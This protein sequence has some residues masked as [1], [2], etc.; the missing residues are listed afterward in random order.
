MKKVKVL[1]I[2]GKINVS[3]GAYHSLLASIKKLKENGIVPTVI[4]PNHGA[5]ED[6]FR[7]ENIEC[8]MVPYPSCTVPADAPSKIKGILKKIQ[9]FGAEKKI[10]KIIERNQYDI[11]HI[12]VGTASAGAKAAIKTGTPLVWH[13]REFLED[14]VNMT[15]IDQAEMKRLL[16]AADHIIAIS[17]A[18]KQA[19]QE[20]YGIEKATTAYNGILIQSYRKKQSFQDPNSV[21]F[22]LVGRIVREKGQLEA[23]KAFA[24]LIMT[25]RQL[26]I[27]L[28]IVGQVGDDKY[29]QEL[30]EYVRQHNLEEQ[31]EF[32]S[33][34]KDLSMLWENTDI[35]LVTSK[36]EGFGRVTAEFMFNNIPVIGAD[37][38]ATTELLSNNRGLLYCYGDADMLAEKMEYAIEHKNEMLKMAHIAHEYA[39]EN[40]TA[41]KNAVEICKIYRD[42]LEKRNSRVK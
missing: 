42:F 8:I 7:S 12:N 35:G 41:E 20:R 39:M 3:N 17:N 11:V 30:V 16:C 36:R 32:I 37:A 21:S 33:H 31:V 24:K 40:F 26:C 15:Y 6:G 29:Y 38:G 34:Q 1:Y 2:A 23:I 14:D 4:V 28:K 9:A 22:M 19:F 27:K 10:K 25:N 13:L 18:V 5:V